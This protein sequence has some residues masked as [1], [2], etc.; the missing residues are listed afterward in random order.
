MEEKNELPKEV[1]EEITL[2]AEEFANSHV[3]GRS[4]PELWEA[5]FKAHE[6][7]ATAYA[8]KLHQANETI[9]VLTYDNNRL[10]GEVEGLAV[11]RK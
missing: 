6:A 8:A 2:T 11:E 4:H 1:V 5:V 9:K 10:K 3:N 7:G